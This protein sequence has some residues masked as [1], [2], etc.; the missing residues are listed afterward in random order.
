LALIITL[1]LFFSLAALFGHFVFVEDF[2]A[3]EPEQRRPANS[4][5]QNPS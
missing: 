1:P 2:N 3:E 5:K 4:L